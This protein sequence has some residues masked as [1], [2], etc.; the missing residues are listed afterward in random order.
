MFIPFSLI[1]IG[2]VIFSYLHDKQEKRI[3][4]LEDEI[5][6]M[7]NGTDFDDSDIF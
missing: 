6:D 4:R 1:I 5:Q 7:R 3:E 2:V